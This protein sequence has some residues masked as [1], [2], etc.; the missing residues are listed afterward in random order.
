MHASAQPRGI[1]QTTK[2]VITILAAVLL[3]GCVNGGTST[4]PYSSSLNQAATAINGL[5]RDGYTVAQGNVYL[6]Q[7]TDCPLFVSIFQSCFGNNA[8]APYIIP[9]P[10]VENAYDDP[11]YATPLDTP[12]PNGANTNII[13][14]LSDTDALLTAVSYPSTGAYFGY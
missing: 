12:G 10:P 7:N 4:S 14:R 8:A 3:H 6:F 5:S 11:S 2:T 1:H 13:Y 9:Q